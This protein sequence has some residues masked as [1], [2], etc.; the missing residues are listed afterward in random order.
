MLQVGLCD[1]EPV[2]LE[3]LEEKVRR[4]FSENLIFAEIQ[5]F[6]AGRNLLYEV[7][8][9]KRFDLLLLDIEM[10]GMDGMELATRLRQLL[11]DALL[12][13]ITSHVEFALDAYELSTFRYIPKNNMEGRLEHALL[14]AAAAIRL[15]QSQSYIISNQNRLERIPLKNLL[16]IQH[17]E[18]NSLLVTDLPA[19]D[20]NAESGSTVHTEFKVRKTLQEIYEELNPEDFLFID[21]GCIV[22]L[23]H[24]MSVKAA[25]CIL[26]D[27]TGLPVS[28]ARMPVLKEHL[29]RF[30]KQ[31]I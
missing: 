20:F 18:K 28:Q 26:R 2:L 15:Q 31:H 14:D 10:P 29:L 6:T 8:D 22:N 7:E 24:V 4:C 1:D 27:G 30:W 17:V 16:Y 19:P 12:I 23:S 3:T 21:R 5:T 13:F 11:P 25:S 9:G